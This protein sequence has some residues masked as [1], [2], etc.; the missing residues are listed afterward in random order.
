LNLWYL[1]FKNVE[2]TELK[3]KVNGDTFEN[4]SNLLQLK[5]NSKIISVENK[6]ETKKRAASILRKDTMSSRKLK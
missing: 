4:E 2:E 5:G 6:P 3:D 1:D